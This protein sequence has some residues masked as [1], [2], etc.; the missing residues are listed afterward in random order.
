MNGRSLPTSIFV[1][2][3]RALGAVEDGLPGRIDQRDGNGLVDEPQHA[4]PL[5]IRVEDVGR[6]GVA[7][8]VAD[9]GVFVQA[10]L[11][12][13]T[14]GSDLISRMPGEYSSSAP[15]ANR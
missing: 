7:A 2:R 5:I 1:R 6:D 4:V 11:H 3:E 8:S 10:H 14:S 9:T 12:E 13:K 15:S